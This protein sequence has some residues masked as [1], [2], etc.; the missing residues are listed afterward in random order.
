MRRGEERKA[1]Y[2]KTKKVKE[3]DVRKMRWNRKRRTEEGGAGVR[4][5]REEDRKQHDK[6]K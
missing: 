2:Q 6:R 4:Q 3:G 5:I 1:E